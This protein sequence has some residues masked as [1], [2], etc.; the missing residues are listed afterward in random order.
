MLQSQP[1]AGTPSRH[2]GAVGGKNAHLPEIVAGGGCP[3]PNPSL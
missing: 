3:S 2:A 1:S